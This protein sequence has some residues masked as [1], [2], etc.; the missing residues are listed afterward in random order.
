MT[1][2]KSDKPDKRAEKG[3][4]FTNHPDGAKVLDLLL[5]KK[6][7]QEKA[8]KQL[9]CTKGN[10]SRLLKK[11]RHVP[12]PEE[13]KIEEEK[14]LIEKQLEELG[15]LQVQLDTRTPPEK[16]VAV[17]WQVI[18][19]GLMKIRDPKLLEPKDFIQISNLIVKMLQFQL[20][21]DMY[22]DIEREEIKLPEDELNKIVE[23]LMA[24]HDNWCP[25]RKEF[26][27]GKDKEQK[28]E[29]LVSQ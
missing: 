15:L 9:G 28:Q 6:I 16:Y 18:L 5:T 3:N 14:G 25:Y 17:A 20:K 23:E 19:Q 26:L 11:Y 1:K 10:I 13:R 22:P 2:S 4:V 12:E 29:R 8:G 21:E 24:D 7:T 27:T